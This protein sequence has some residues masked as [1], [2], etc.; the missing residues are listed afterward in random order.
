MSNE[1]IVN[2]WRKLPEMQFLP[3]SANL[4]PGLQA[5]WNFFADLSLTHSCAHPWIHAVRSQGWTKNNINKEMVNFT[6]YTFKPS[7][8]LYFFK[9]AHICTP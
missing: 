8:Q 7:K 2:Q 5:Q 9:K 4:N 1:L 6:E 3:F